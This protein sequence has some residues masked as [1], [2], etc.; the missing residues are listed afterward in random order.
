LR[1][2]FSL[3]G[4]SHTF[5]FPHAG[6]GQTSGSVR[7]KCWATPR[8]VAPHS[9]QRKAPEKSSG[10]TSEVR[11]TVPA[12]AVRRPILEVVSARRRS[13]WGRPVKETQNSRGMSS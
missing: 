3:S 6:T 8:T 10:R 5:R 12:N 13:T 11:V 2:A 1:R 7:L 4:L 9:R